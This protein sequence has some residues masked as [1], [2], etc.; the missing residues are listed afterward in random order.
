[1]DSVLV[2]CEPMWLAGYLNQN[3]NFLSPTLWLL[4]V[5]FGLSEKLIWFF[6]DFEN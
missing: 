4:V 1:M 5:N 3:T 6:Y 2:Y